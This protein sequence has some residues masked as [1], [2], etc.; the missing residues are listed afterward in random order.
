MSFSSE[1]KQELCA[2]PPA[3]ACCKRAE[4]AGLVA[5]SGSLLTDSSGGG[6]RIRTE[7]AAVAQRAYDLFTALFSVR[8][9]RTAAQKKP[10]GY[11][12]TLR[13]YASQH[14]MQMMKALGLVRDE[15]VRFCAD[16]FITAEPC[17]RRAFLRGAF[18]G[19]GSVNAPEKSYH[20]EIET[21]Y[22][23]LARDLVQL[24]ADEDITARRVERKSNQVIYV[25][26]S[27]EIA[28]VLAALGATD[29]ALA[30]YSIKIEKDMKNKVN[31]RVNCE[32][33]NMTKTAN[34]A[35]VQILAIQKIMASPC[36]ATL[37]P[38]LLELASLRVENPEASLKEL[39][40]MLDV[41]LSKSAVSRRLQK[42]V[43]MAEGLTV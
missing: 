2:L 21:H 19:G 26:D 29:S 37:S 1:V 18:L 34:T 7:N 23:D 25:K 10:S 42:L 4:L 5:L 20:L 32:T 12:H 24:F 35:A 8:P 9:T 33:A 30:L 14:Y 15:R 31:R 16:P 22:Q 43:D 11:I 13:L 17:C 41:P 27:Q 28:D 39:G 40:A 6:L 38:P 3:A 36:S